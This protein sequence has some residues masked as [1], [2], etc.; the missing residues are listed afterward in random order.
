MDYIWYIANLVS[1]EKRWAQKGKGQK[2][3]AG[4]LRQTQGANGTFFGAN[5]GKKIKRSLTS[6]IFVSLFLFSKTF[7]IVFGHLG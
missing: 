6:K 2:A 4:F 1:E 7:G 5:E 3:A